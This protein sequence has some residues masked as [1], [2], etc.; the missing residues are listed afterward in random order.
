MI[1]KHGVKVKDTNHPIRKRQK[2]IYDQEER[3]RKLV[4]AILV[5]VLI[6]IVGGAIVGFAY[7]FASTRG[8]I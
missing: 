1:L 8:F 2:M 6:L 7:L 4:E 5:G 3:R